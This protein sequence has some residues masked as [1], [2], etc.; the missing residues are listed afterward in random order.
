MTLTEIILSQLPE[1]PLAG[2]RR[3]DEL[4]R[5]L[6]EGTLPVP[7]VVQESP[8]RLGA[9][10]WDVVICGGTLGILIGAAL[11]QQG[12][13][14]A[15]LERGMLRG[16]QQEWNISR[17]EL[18]AFVELGLLT[19]QELDQ[20]IATEYNPAR[21]SFLGGADLWVQDVLNIGVDPLYLLETLKQRFLSGGG[22]LF[23]QI[24]FT[25]AIVHPDGVVI[26]TEQESFTARLLLDA[27]G[28]F[29]P[30]VRQ[31][32][33]GKRPEA[34]C[35]VVGT[36]ATGFPPND[37]GD[38]IVSFTPVQDQCQY[39]WEAFPARDGRTTYLFTYLDADP[40]RFSLETLFEEYFRLLPEYQQVTLEQLQFQRALFGCFPCYRQSPLKPQWHRILPIGD[41]SGSQSP[42][43]FG[44]FGAMVRHLNRLTYGIHDALQ[45]DTLERS[46]LALLQPYQPNLAV[47]W[48]FQRA[49]SVGINQK[50]PP[51][52]INQ[53]LSSVF[54][55]MA[56]L[57]E[58]VLKPFLQDVV[59]FPALFQTLIRTSIAHPKLVL[60]ILPH[61]GLVTIL[62]WLVHYM[63]LASYTAL[64]SITNALEPASKT[65]PPV[66][67]YYYRRWLQ[68]FKY[69]A[70]KDYSN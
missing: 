51:N 70:G 68:A 17:H 39:F 62:D 41:S 26:Q 55:Q 5:S 10:A 8:E 43:S 20:A 45:T 33:Q 50:I 34:V 14:V 21:I 56:A 60:Q 4:W 24:A 61:V 28:H 52:Q 25:G 13:R 42:L 3:T 30:I 6:R 47:T 66:P 40:D 63:N 46:A 38:L 54:A 44:G 53:L 31:S 29:S 58:P 37:T 9:V 59:Q 15:L 35:L 19:T 32:R 12:W 23:E 64:F 16:R 36:C 7:T 1:N 18:Q 69:G 57:G 11:V 49:M 27:M 2:L 67:Q 65:L 22:Q 48:L